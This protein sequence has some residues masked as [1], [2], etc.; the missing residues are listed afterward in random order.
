MTKDTL[1]DLRSQ[2]SIVIGFAELLR[3]GTINPTS[4]KY[5]EA[6]DAI[7]SASRQALLLTDTQGK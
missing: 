1:H 7:L 2:L 5:K 4:S 3:N 6:L